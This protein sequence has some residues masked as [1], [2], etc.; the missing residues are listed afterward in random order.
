[1]ADNK[2]CPTTLPNSRTPL[3]PPQSSLT[4]HSGR[5]GQLM[6]STRRRSLS[7]CL[8]HSGLQFSP[9]ANSDRPLCRRPDR[10]PAEPGARGAKHSGR[11][12]S[13]AGTSPPPVP[14]PRAES[15]AAL[16]K[17][18]S[19]QPRSQSQSSRGLSLTVSAPVGSNPGAVAPW[20]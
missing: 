17:R 20:L 12:R 15:W 19:N 9:K 4:R 8:P 7:A 13:Q 2:L 18:P 5:C 6:T 10:W 16:I 1:M 3:T 14:M 11:E